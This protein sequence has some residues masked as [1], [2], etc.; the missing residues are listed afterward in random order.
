MNRLTLI[1][2]LGTMLVGGGFAAAQTTPP[3]AADEHAAHHPAAAPAAPKGAKEQKPAE[4]GKGGAM[5][6]GGMMGGGMM[7]GG[8]MGGGMMG[9]C[10]MMS[11]NAK[12]DVTK[13][14]KGVTITIASDD[15]K[16]VARAQ[17]MAEAM[18]LMHEANAP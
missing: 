4:K 6:G 2:A 15:P 17:K 3:K 10:P 12:F 18:R 11:A 13:T 16:V 9:M 8:M 7:G 1:A 5:M 14:A